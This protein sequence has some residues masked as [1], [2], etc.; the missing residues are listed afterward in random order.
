MIKK[1][2][3]FQR[4][5]RNKST[6]IN[7]EYICSGAYRRKFDSLSDNKKLNRLVY[8]LAKKMLHHRTGTEYEDMYW[9][10]ID[11]LEIVAE[12]LDMKT[13]KEIV[14]SEKT[15]KVMNEYRKRPE[16]RLLTIHTHPSSFP[17]SIPDF[18]ANYANEYNLGIVICHDGT[19]YMYAAC[20][21]INENF[22]KLLVAKNLN[23]GY[24]EHEASFLALRQMQN[25]FQMMIKEVTDNG[26]NGR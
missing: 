22:Y 8:K 16:K 20:E 2:E 15:K 24:N 26:N 19:I 10:D 3:E 7:K 18:N 5:G 12:E 4:N 13:R 6:Q 11:T 14:Y 25:I 17:P 21:E 1:E 9:I 23:Q